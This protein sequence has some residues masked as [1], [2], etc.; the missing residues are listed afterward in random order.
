[1]GCLMNMGFK[2]F[3]SLKTAALRIALQIFTEIFFNELIHPFCKLKSLSGV[4]FYRIRNVAR[5][6]GF[7]CPN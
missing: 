1:M 5:I 3:G 4:G 2:G 6:P 7:Y